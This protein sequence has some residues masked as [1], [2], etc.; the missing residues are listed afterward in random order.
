MR[1]HLALALAL[2][3]VSL[4]VTGALAASSLSFNGAGNGAGA[5]P[6]TARGVGATVA[7]FTLSDAG[8]QQ[9]ALSALKGAKGT[10]LV[11]LSIQCPVVKAYD[12]RIEQLAKAY[13]A[14]GINFIGLNANSTETADEIKSHASTHYTFPVLIDRDNKIADQ[15]GA[16]RTPEIFF[17]D[18][19]NKIVYHGRIDNNRDK[20]M[21]SKSELSDAIEAVLAGKPVAVTET[22]SV[23]CTIKKKKSY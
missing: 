14:K 6:A 4:F 2:A 9:H 21:V 13:K 3:V 11:F 16:E 15:L 8:G 10:V 5:G 19:S 22:A 7:D 1:K 17:L 12:E 23:G 18:A 20:A